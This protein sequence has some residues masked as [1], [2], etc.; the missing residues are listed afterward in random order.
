MGGAFPTLE[1]LQSQAVG[2]LLPSSYKD[3]QVFW[4]LGNGGRLSVYERSN[5]EAKLILDGSIFESES[6]LH[7]CKLHS[8][9]T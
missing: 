8:V 9:S 6:R 4:C 1:A 3:I 7:V 2:D 5:E